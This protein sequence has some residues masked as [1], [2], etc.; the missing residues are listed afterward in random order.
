MTQSSPL[1]NLPAELR[2]SMYELVAEETT[3]VSLKLGATWYR[4]YLSLVWRQLRDE[5]EKVFLKEAPK[6][7]TKINIHITDFIWKSTQFNLCDDLLALP[8]PLHTLQCGC[9]LRVTLT[10]NRDAYR[11]QLNELCILRAKDILPCFDVDVRFDPDNFD[12]E[13]WRRKGLTLREAPWISAMDTN[14]TY[15]ADS[16]AREAFL[17]RGMEFDFYLESAFERRVKQHDLRKAETHRRN[18]P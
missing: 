1:F 2:N 8:I 6:Y 10:N 16:Y 14:P 11:D 12:V 13:Y 9:T 5:Y 15:Y 17:S 4:P 7:A 3:S 18:L